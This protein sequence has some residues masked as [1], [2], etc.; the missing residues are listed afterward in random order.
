MLLNLHIHLTYAGDALVYLKP[1]PTWSS[2]TWIQRQDLQENYNV[3]LITGTI[4]RAGPDW[5][6]GISQGTL[7]DKLEAEC[8]TTSWEQGGLF[9][10]LTHDSSR[11]PQ[12]LALMTHISICSPYSYIWSDVRSVLSW[13]CLPENRWDFVSAFPGQCLQGSKFSYGI[14]CLSNCFWRWCKIAPRMTRVQELDNV[15]CYTLEHPFPVHV[16]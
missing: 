14:T 10:Q 11:L 3:K 1:Y 5:L 6:T 4:D 2:Y 9:N 12:P 7:G 13:K 8:I 16:L 15:S